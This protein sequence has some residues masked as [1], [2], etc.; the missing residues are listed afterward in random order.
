MRSQEH[1]VKQQFNGYQNMF[2]IIEGL[3]KDQESRRNRAGEFENE[4][5]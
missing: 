4:L 5:I 1:E 2:K 3:R